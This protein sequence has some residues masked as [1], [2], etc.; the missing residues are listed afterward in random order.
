MSETL[1]A[2]LR[3]LAVAVRVEVPADLEATVMARVNDPS[4]ARPRRLRRWIAGLFLAL[5]GAGAVAS[6]VGASILDW[7]GFHGVNVVEGQP[8][9]TEEPTV[10]AE[11]AA[12]DLDEAAE[13]AGFTPLVPAALGT[14]DGVAV[15]ADRRVVSLSWGSGADT[16]RL[17]EFRGTI[18]PQFWKTA[19]DASI[20]TIA[21]GDALWLPTAHHVEVV[22]DDGTRQRLAPRLAAPTLVWTQGDLTLRLEGDH[23]FEAAVEIA[24]SAG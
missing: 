6:P 16:V 13:L 9:V 22:A 7:F 14:P 2:R 1:E 12:V 15:S 8:P 4:P 17:D 11:P 21:V 23:S 19:Q 3:E 10:P 24:E 20:V 5:L 18:D